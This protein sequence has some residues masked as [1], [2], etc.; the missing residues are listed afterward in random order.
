MFGEICL[1]CEGEMSKK[2]AIAFIAICFLG[3]AQAD[4]QTYV[5]TTPATTQT[6][7]Q[8]TGTSLNVNALNYVLYVSPTSGVDW[9]TQVNALFASCGYNCDVHRP[10][11]SYTTSTGAVQM[12]HASQSLSGDGPTLVYIVASQQRY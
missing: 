6:V 3:S 10:A 7:T 2:V 9:V 12:Y 1:T 5:T 11:G 8:P 4:A